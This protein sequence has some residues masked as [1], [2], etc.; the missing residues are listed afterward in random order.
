MTQQARSKPAF[1]LQL[2]FICKSAQ[3]AEELGRMVWS[4]S[5]ASIYSSREQVQAAYNHYPA[6][7]RYRY[8][9]YRVVVGSTG[10]IIN[11]EGVYPR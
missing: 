6:S 11:V 10:E 7:L 4:G 8:G 1:P 9:I 2:F 5:I 3:T